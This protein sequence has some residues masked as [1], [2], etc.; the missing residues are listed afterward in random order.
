MRVFLDT[1]IIIDLLDNSRKGCMSAALIFEAA[2]EGFLDVCVSA[3]SIT[4]CAYIARKKPLVVFRSA[5]SRILPFV[6]VL[7]LTKDHL[8][9]ASSASCPDF[10]EAALIACAEENLCDVIITSNTKHFKDFT[11]IK[12]HTPKE[13]VRLVE[14]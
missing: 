10:E 6:D 3:Q 8:A 4:D 1:N 9:K 14:G 13:F 7:P 12:V 5:I 2:K 11:F